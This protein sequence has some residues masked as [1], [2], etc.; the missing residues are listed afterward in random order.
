[1]AMGRQ[2]WQNMVIGTARIERENEVI[3]RQR[4]DNIEHL[5]GYQMRHAQRIMGV[6][7]SISDAGKIFTNN[8]RYSAAAI[9]CG[10]Q[11]CA[12]INYNFRALT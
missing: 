4:G 3:E 7:G 10:R 8:V 6:S 12:N 5:T 1:M 2:F 11:Y 9:F